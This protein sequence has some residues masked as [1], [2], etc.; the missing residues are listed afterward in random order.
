MFS[1]RAIMSH[2]HQVI[3]FGSFLDKGYAEGG[4]V[5]QAPLSRDLFEEGAPDAIP[6]VDDKWQSYW[7]GFRK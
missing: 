5:H 3:Y 6:Q 2:L 1:H 7:D 4:P